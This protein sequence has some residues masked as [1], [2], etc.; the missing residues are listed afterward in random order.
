V[1]FV[2]RLNDALGS[3][4]EPLATDV[5]ARSEQARRLMP[6]G[7]TS[8][9]AT[10]PPVLGRGGPVELTQ[11]KKVFDFKPPYPGR[12]LLSEQQA[13][14]ELEGE[15]TEHGTIVRP[16]PVKGEGEFRTV[17]QQAV[18][19]WRFDPPRVRGCGVPAP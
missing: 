1:W 7:V 6:T 11:P 8:A 15:L 5:T 16:V 12:A 13:V 9:C 4:P 2:T 3:T 18:L 19:L 10:D 17:A 14:V